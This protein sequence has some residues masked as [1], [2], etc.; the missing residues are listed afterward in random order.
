MS[1]ASPLPP[2]L[3]IWIVNPFDDIPGEGLPPLRYWSLAR[4]L[5][6]RGHDV[7]WWSSTWSHRRKA[8][9]RVPLGIRED[10][11]FAMRLVAVRPY[12]KNASLARFASHRDFSRTFERLANESIA[13]GQLSR[14]DLILASLSPLEGPEAA[15]RLAQRLD[16]QCIVDLTEIWPETLERLV[17]GPQWLRKILSPLL[18]GGM[19]RRRKIVIEAADG[20][21]AATQAYANAILGEGVAQQRDDTPD[22]PFETAA[23]KPHFVCYLGAYVEE[24]AAPPRNYNPVPTADQAIKNVQARLVTES[25][26]CVYSGTL[27]A[28]QDL[29]TLIAAA[30]MLSSSG[31][32][33]TLHIAGTG[34]LEASLRQSAA[35]LSGSCRVLTHGLLSRGAYAKLLSECAVGLVLVKPESLVS[36]PYKACDYAAAGLAIVNSLPGELEKLIDHFGA[37][38][39][40]TSGNATSLASAISSLAD[41]RTRL[42]HFRQNARL[43]AAV[44]FDRERIYPRFAEWLESIAE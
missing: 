35:A 24:F 36:V 34:S 1:R 44:E 14:P 26:E 25:L 5:A 15:L 21:S 41:D 38:I 4:I 19:Y 23:S 27:E 39:R 17:P 7:T 8:I 43:L 18:L 3:T 32:K 6:G 37:G 30:K 10:E 2:P 20:I 33:A 11:G 9:R 42:L 40:Y 22:T 16:A 31:T 28:G 13:S 12:Q 29:D